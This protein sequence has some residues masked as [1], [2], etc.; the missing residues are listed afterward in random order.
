MA[1]L[2]SALGYVRLPLALRLG[3]LVSYVATG[4]LAGLQ[5][6]HGP[7]RLAGPSGVPL[8]HCWKFHVV[9]LAA[10]LAKVRGH[11]STGVALGGIVY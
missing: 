2:L 11:A 10:P 9:F 1:V 8:K 4:R 3:Q 6:P 5:E 7:R